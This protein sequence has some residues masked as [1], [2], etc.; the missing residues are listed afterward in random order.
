M[1]QATFF[2]AHAQVWHCVTRSCAFA[3]L[4]C[5]CF[6][7]LVDYRVLCVT[8]FLLWGC[9]ALGAAC[10]FSWNA[11][12]ISQRK[13]YKDLTPNGNMHFIALN[14]NLTSLLLMIVWCLLF[15]HQWLQLVSL[16][17]CGPTAEAAAEGSQQEILSCRG[18][19]CEAT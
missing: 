9:R 11:W 12:T 10:F 6:V 19:L 2:W 14:K 17:S 8:F 5:A 16:A 15:V 1:F 4:L 13:A 7:L 18:Y 3:S